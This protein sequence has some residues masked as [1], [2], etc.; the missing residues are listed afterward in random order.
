[1]RRS[2]S[3][4]AAAALFPL[5]DAMSPAS[6]GDIPA[7][8]PLLHDLPPRCT[9]Y[10]INLFCQPASSFPIRQSLWSAIFLA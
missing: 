10:E 8:H 1:M 9:S 3:L 7:L 6:L 4:S 5:S 2:F